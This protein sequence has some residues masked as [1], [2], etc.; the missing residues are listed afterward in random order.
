MEHYSTDD[1]DLV[2]V[3]SE[4][5]GYAFDDDL[6]LT[7]HSWSSDG[8]VDGV[9]TSA[10]HGDEIHEL[11]ARGLPFSLTVRPAGTGEALTIDDCVFLSSSG[12]W[13]G[14]A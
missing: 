3:E 1:G 9:L 12:K 2:R 13:V 10:T 7:V 5:G 4:I 11:Y 8:P 6:S 14:K